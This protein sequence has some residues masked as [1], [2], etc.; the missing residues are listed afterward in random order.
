MMNKNRGKKAGL[1]LLIGVFLLS[2]AS[3]Q[4]ALILQIVLKD[5]RQI[6]WE[7]PISS[8]AVFS[9]THLNSIYDAPVEEAFRVDDRGQIWLKALRTESA[10]VL[11]YY[12]LEEVSRE[13]ISLSRPVGRISLIITRRGAVTLGLE[14]EEIPL[15]QLLPDGARVELRAVSL[16]SEPACSRLPF[17]P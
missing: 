5:T 10:A 4:A 13:W 16:K 9:L 7:R 6:Y 17:N 2:P 11:E 12:G 15:S 1:W 8:G 14:N 3:L